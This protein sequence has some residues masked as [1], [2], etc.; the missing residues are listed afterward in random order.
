MKTKTENIWTQVRVKKTTRDQ[1]IQLE[2]GRMTVED[3]IQRLIE[4]YEKDL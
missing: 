1:L 4:H 2:V 3:V